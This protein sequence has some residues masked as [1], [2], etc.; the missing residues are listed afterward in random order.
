MTPHLLKN[1]TVLIHNDQDHVSAVKTDILVQDSKIIR[2]AADIPNSGGAATVLDCTDKIIAPG[3]VDTHHHL[4]QTQLRGRHSNQTLLQYFIPGNFAS[5]CYQPDDVFWG[6]LGGALEAIDGGITT[7]VDH[8]HVNHSPAHT[9]AAVRATVASGIRSIYGYCPISRA[10]SLQPFKRI[11]DFFPPWVMDTFDKLTTIN[12]LANGRVMLGF[13]FD[14]LFLPKEI[15]QPVFQKVMDAGAQ[16][17]TT[18]DTAGPMMGN[19]P[20]KLTT[21]RSLGLLSP[22][23]RTIISHANDIPSESAPEMAAN[24]VFISNTPSSELQMGNGKAHN[25]IPVAFSD[26]ALSPF[27]SIGI[28]CQTI[29][30]GFIPS[31][32]RELLGAARIF[33]HYEDYKHNKWH[34]SL[35]PTQPGAGFPSVEQAFNVATIG[36][37]RAV[38]LADK[39][40]RIKKGYCA[41][42]VIWD[43]CSPNMVAGADENPVGSVVLH[44]S[45]RDVFG[46]VIDGKIRKWE[47]QLQDVDTSEGS[48]APLTE[49]AL[50]ESGVLSWSRI[51]QEIRKSRKRIVKQLESVDFKAGEDV[52]IKEFHMNAEGMV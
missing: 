50:P 36:G 18:H 20:S 28:D 46:V 33:R 5:F 49:Y 47:G 13:A 19:A 9:Y 14:G 41:D 24:N 27:T 51:S 44:S 30:S 42:L 29:S 39:L 1:G 26:P 38:G 32:L 40:G 7:V 3:F 15:L 2:V 10:E 6:Q 22:K 11:W 43:G 37:A 16:V 34:R 31:Q 12:P 23:L 8:S 4:W 21:L 35:S 52:L 17:F 25:P 48:T 45:V